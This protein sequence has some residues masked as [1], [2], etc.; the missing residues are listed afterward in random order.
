MCHANK[1]IHCSKSNPESSRTHRWAD[2]HPE[3][4]GYCWF[5]LDATKP[6]PRTTGFETDRC[7]LAIFR[8]SL[9]CFFRSVAFLMLDIRTVSKGES[10]E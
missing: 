4:H 10:N 2:R 5:R 9:P 1:Q 7:V 6:H 3:Y 8:L